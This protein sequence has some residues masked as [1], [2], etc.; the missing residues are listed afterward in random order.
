MPLIDAFFSLHIDEDGKKKCIR[1]VVEKIYERLWNSVFQNFVKKPFG[2]IFVE[3]Q[4]LL[5][6]NLL[7]YVFMWSFEHY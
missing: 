3:K 2:I 1:N 6:F 5:E 7:W 4:T